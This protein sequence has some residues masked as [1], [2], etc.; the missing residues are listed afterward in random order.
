[1]PVKQKLSSR[2]L[3]EKDKKILMVL[4]KD[5]RAQLKEI[6]KKVSDYSW[7]AFGGQELCL[8]CQ[9]KERIKT[10][11]PKMAE[12]VNKQI[13]KKYQ[14]QDDELSDTEM[15]MMDSTYDNQK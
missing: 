5:G 4:Q 12:V 13:E 14:G 2:I 3:D 11:P 8:D 1:M 15:E 10:M 6:S 9:K 7:R